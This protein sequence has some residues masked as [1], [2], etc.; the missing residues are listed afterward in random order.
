MS[1]GGRVALGLRGHFQPLPP[2]PVDFKLVKLF[3]LGVVRLRVF[4]RCLFLASWWVAASSASWSCVGWVVENVF[5]GLRGRS[6]QFGFSSGAA[7]R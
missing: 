6:F 7:T 1:F 2:I 4:F 5:F 3:K